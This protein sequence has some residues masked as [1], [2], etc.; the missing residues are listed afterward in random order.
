M[1]SRGEFAIKT[2]KH[3]NSYTEIPPPPNKMLMS[4]GNL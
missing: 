3:A 4:Q 2:I 1:K